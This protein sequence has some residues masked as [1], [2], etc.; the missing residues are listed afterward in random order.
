MSVSQTADRRRETFERLLSE[1][2][3]E[4]FD[5]YQ[6]G[7]ALIQ[8]ASFPGRAALLGHVVRELRRRVPNAFVPRPEQAQN[9]SV[10]LR[11]L[12]P[13]WEPV[14]IELGKLEEESRPGDTISVPVNLARR[15]DEIFI[16]EQR[17]SVT[18]R[19]RFLQM[20]AIINKEGLKWSG[21]QLLAK[22]WVDINAEGIA[23]GGQV[24]CD[25]E[26][27]VVALFNHQEDILLKIFEYAQERK[28]RIIALA[29]AATVENLEASLKEVVTLTDEST[30]FA[31]LRRPE[32]L[33]TLR[34]LGTFDYNK[35]KRPHYWPPADYLA[36]V[37][38][39][40][41]DTVAAILEE[42]PVVPA[43]VTR[44]LLNVAL[45]LSDSAL[46]SIAQN[47]TWFAKPVPLFGFAEPYFTALAR[48]VTF[49]HEDLALKRASR[50]LKL[51][52]NASNVTASPF[53][54]PT[55]VP[56]A[57][58]EFFE[59]ILKYFATTFEA[60]EAF[61]VIEV[62]ANSLDAAI[63]LENRDKDELRAMWVGSLTNLGSVY[64]DTKKLLISTLLSFLRRAA[65]GDLAATLDVLATRRYNGTLY[66]RLSMALI[67]EVRSK[68]DARGVLNDGA[69]WTVNDP[70]HIAILERFYPEYDES[71]RLA[72]ARLA[73]GALESRL[74]PYYASQSVAETEIK[75]LVDVAFVSRFGTAKDSL[76]PQFAAALA[77]FEAASAPAPAISVE[78]L[79]AMSPPD[80]VSLLRTLEPRG[81]PLDA[82]GIGMALQAAAQANG[83]AWISVLESVRE[84][85]A[86]Y[87][88]WLLNGLV[89]YHRS[90]D[91]DLAG[92]FEACDIGINRA[93]SLWTST[94]SDNRAAALHIIQAS[95]LSLLD[96]ARA[97]TDDSILTR[98][99]AIAV[100][101]GRLSPSERDETKV[102]PWT[103]SNS[104]LGDPQ[105]I[106][107]NLAAELLGKAYRGH[108]DYS[109]ILQIYDGLSEVDSIAV[110]GA[111]GQW[112]AWFASVSSQ[113]DLWAKRIFLSGNDRADK[114]AWSGYVLFTQV[115]QL[116]YRLLKPAYEERLVDL[117][118]A[119]GWRADRGIATPE[120]GTE[121]RQVQDAF[122]GHIWTLLA[123]R[124][125]TLENPQSLTNRALDAVAD[126]LLEDLVK[127]IAASLPRDDDSFSQQV[128]DE[129]MK[130]WVEIARRYDQGKYSAA[131][132]GALPALIRSS[133]LPSEWRIEQAEYLA[134]RFERE[135]ITDWQL[136]QDIRDL[137]AV[138]RKRVL[139][140]LLRLAETTNFAILPAIQ[141]YAGPLL[142]AAHASSDPEEQQLVD[143]IISI[144]VSN[145]RPNILEDVSSDVAD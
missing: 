5:L 9:P 100:K 110:R 91:G 126:T 46:H 31:E 123:N 34:D 78:Q 103:A 87:L 8:S 116:T 82:W 80:V 1:R 72:I 14:S 28:A 52:A 55:A 79:A 32:L 43:A 44:Q 63:S 40:D 47:A 112:F 130:F 11:K 108:A 24:G 114:A 37:A 3:P 117:S 33:S 88:G 6:G 132:L 106:A 66:Q 58:I 35:T 22:E 124:I 131:I 17:V 71:E 118:T 75:R 143:R 77:N 29:E 26:E 38:S 134:A 76:P 104:A 10:K 138:D 48:L 94:S 101:L 122:L 56:V 145:Q 20:C 111:L 19:E 141:M 115:N 96:W 54:H 13:D 92:V 128:R 21:N 15:F 121:A 64:N 144:L 57:G 107:L 86:Q 68:D 142:R 136:V 16:D 113:A 97:S 120:D 67:L 83:A 135:T 61:P 90:A 84:M 60:A 12:L 41:P 137:A 51:T 89:A 62:L 139:R 73:Y 59:F 85:P 125:E 69:L 81:W 95:G 7:R 102:S 74:R 70:E 109:E 45:T 140:I 93:E 53:N 27:L 39:D 65:Q 2:D 50:F 25:A 105:G 18:L 98:L 127:Q 119:Q 23:H 36:N 42:L 133:A 30:F 49:G 99:T 129:A 4:L